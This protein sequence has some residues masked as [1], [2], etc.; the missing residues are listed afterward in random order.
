MCGRVKTDIT[1]MKLVKEKFQH[2]HIGARFMDMCILGA[3][4]L[5]NESMHIYD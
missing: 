5:V 2:K 1:G 4:M 3:V